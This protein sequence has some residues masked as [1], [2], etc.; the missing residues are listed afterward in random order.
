MD[1]SPSANLAA[2]LTAASSAAFLPASPVPTRLRF[3]RPL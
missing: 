1:E 2:I 3:R